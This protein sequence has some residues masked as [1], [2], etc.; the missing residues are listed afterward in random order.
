MCWGTLDKLPLSRAV[1]QA[2]L[3]H[4]QDRHC[5]VV[6]VHC[7]LRPN[8]SDLEGHWD[9]STP[10]Y[11]NVSLLIWIFLQSCLLPSLKSTTFLRCSLTQ[12]VFGIFEEPFKHLSQVSLRS[13]FLVSAQ[14]LRKDRD[15]FVSNLPL[16][17]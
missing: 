12:G 3:M 16:H 11:A 5:K 1:T 14:A 10:L 8:L 15:L 9:S 17:G 6:M 2:R 13:H 4:W 7:V